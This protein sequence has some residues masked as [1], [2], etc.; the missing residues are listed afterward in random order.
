MKME[1]EHREGRTR[2]LSA[3]GTGAER[4]AADIAQ[5]GVR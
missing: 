3:P 5:A 1:E 4:L 2:P